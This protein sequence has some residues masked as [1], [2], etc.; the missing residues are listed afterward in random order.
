MQHTYSEH[1]I[2]L[3]TSNN[4]MTG[5]FPS[6]LVVYVDI[7]YNDISTEQEISYLFYQYVVNSSITNLFVLIDK[8]RYGYILLGGTYLQCG[9]RCIN[10][11]LNFYNLVLDTHIVRS[12]SKK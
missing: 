3:I 10:S 8:R 5:I 2:V 1:K 7:T 9:K 12:T 11:I 6:S 4:G